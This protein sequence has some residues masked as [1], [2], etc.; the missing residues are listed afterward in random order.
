MTTPRTILLL[1]L[2]ASSVA[3]AQQDHG[4]ADALYQ[5]VGLLAGL[6]GGGV[7]LS[8]AALK[9]W[10]ALWE[11]WERAKSERHQ[12]RRIVLGREG[13]GEGVGL[14]GRLEAIETAM[15]SGD[16]ETAREL[17][18]LRATVAGTPH[19]GTDGPTAGP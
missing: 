11:P 8:F 15:R 1:T 4:Q 18:A 12:L 10:A 19:G 16:T 7:G 17:R 6:V 2:A 14:V 5:S 9:L 13:G 3:M